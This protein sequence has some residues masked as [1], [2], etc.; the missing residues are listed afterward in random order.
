MRIIHTADW[1]LGRKLKGRDR[2][3]E[4]ELQLQ[5]LTAYAIGHEVDAVLVA[6]DIF[7]HAN[8]STE[9]ERV[10]YQ[11]FA[12]LQH[13]NIPAVA[14]AGNHDSAFRIDSVAHIL[15]L[16]N[17]TALGKPRRPD[18]GGIVRVETAS[19]NLCVAAMPFAS[20]RRFLSD[21]YLWEKTGGERLQ[22]YR[23]R[24]SKL[25]GL[26][27]KEFRAGSVNILMAHLAIA[28]AQLSHSE[29]EF[30]TTGAYSLSEQTL[31]DA[32]YIALGHIHKQQ[33]IANAVAPTYY[34]GSL[35]QVDF[36]ECNEDKGFNL[37]TVEPG[38]LAKVE[39]VTLPCPKP[40]REIRCKADDLDSELEA[41]RNH[42]GWLKVIVELDEPRS[43]L[44]ERVKQVCPQTLHVEARYRRSDKAQQRVEPQQLRSVEGARDRFR[45]Y[46]RDRKGGTEPS[47]AVLAIFEDLYREVQE[48]RRAPD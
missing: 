45:S 40:L 41:H 1:H 2:T 20:E 48:E 10:A 38:K 36:G 25:L 44:A 46:Y 9:A 7:D 23:D 16:A 28:G 11:F 43:H 15:S 13:A 6:G 42:P 35:I 27:A 29:R 3:P 34:S 17:V 24:V 22:N 47:P 19:G 18:D 31:P 8:P 4:I 21:E 39:F 12:S 37:V 33:K 30:E 14:I 26:L 32:Q 5:A